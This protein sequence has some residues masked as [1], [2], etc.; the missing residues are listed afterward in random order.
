MKDLNL[1]KLVV[2]ELRSQVNIQIIQKMLHLVALWNEDTALTSTEQSPAVVLVEFSV[3]L[4]SGVH[5]V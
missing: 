1:G 2:R 4:A 5:C 3:G